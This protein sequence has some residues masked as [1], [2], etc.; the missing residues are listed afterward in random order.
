MPAQKRTCEPGV[1]E[2]LVQAPQRYQ[3]AQAVRLLVRWLADHGVPYEQAYTDVLRFQASLSLAFPAGDIE[4][5]QMEGAPGGTMPR[6]VRLTPACIGLLGA[7]GALPFHYTERIAAAEAD[8][9]LAGAKPFMDM[10]AQ[11]MVALYC[12]A[13]GKHRLEHSLDMGGADTQRPL[14][15]ALGGNAALFRAAE[16]EGAIRADTAARYAGLLRAR[17]ASAVAISQVLSEYFGVPVRLEQFDGCWD[18]IPVQARST[19]GVTRPRL[20]HGAVLGTRVWRHDR[21]ARLDIGPLKRDELQRFLPRGEAAAAL[22]A[23]LKLFGAPK[24][25]YEVRLI[26]GAS[27]IGPI[28]LAPPGARRRLGWDTFLPDKAGKV[29]RPEVRYRLTI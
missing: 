25:R 5:L 26:L 3:F 22:A 6:H 19:L 23:M 10:L 27:C 28:V 12:Q 29:A 7:N 13:W 20:G 14:L 1:I 2:R 15:L 16:A 18:P 4:A 21:Q 17:P 11:R 8:P 24:L 9:E